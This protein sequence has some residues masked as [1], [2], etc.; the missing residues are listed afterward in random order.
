MEKEAQSKY[1]EGDRV[2][3]FYLEPELLQNKY[4][5]IGW[6]GK[7][8]KVDP[9]NQ[10]WPYI[11]KLDNGKQNT[12]SFSFGSRNEW[13]FNDKEIKLESETENIDIPE[14]PWKEEGNNK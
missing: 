12:V 6:T 1:K 7:I 14:I 8:I 10:W 3:I 2:K 9:F 4:L 11:V 5:E 13:N